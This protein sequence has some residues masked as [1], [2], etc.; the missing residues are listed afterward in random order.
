MRVS[1][2]RLW[3]DSPPPEPCPPREGPLPYPL[4]TL[5]ILASLA[6]SLLL[7]SLPYQQGSPGMA[8]HAPSRPPSFGNRV[9]LTGRLEFRV[10][11]VRIRRGGPGAP[12]RLS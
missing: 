5:T 10:P 8:K 1:N 7:N 9:L 12:V 11:G 4:G 3:G 6:N 2:R